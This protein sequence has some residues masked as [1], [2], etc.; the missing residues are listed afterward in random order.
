MNNKKVIFAVIAIFLCIAAAICIPAFA[1]DGYAGLPANIESENIAAYAI[2]EITDISGRK[3]LSKA[4]DLNYKTA[5]KSSSK[6]DGFIIKF[7]DAQTFN[8][9][10]LREKD[11]KVRSFQ[12]SYLAK[13]E[14]GEHWEMFYKQDAI[15]DFRLCAFDEITTSQLKFE[16][17][18]AT[19]IFNI[20]EIEIYN[21]PKKERNKFRVSDYLV[22]PEVASGSSYDPLSENYF[23]PQYCSTINQLHLI[24]VACWNDEGELVINDGY[25]RETIA[26]EV[27]KIREIYGEN[28]VDIFAT[29]F[30]NRCNPT[31][32]LTEHKDEVI[33]NTVDFLVEAGFDGVSYDW[34]YPI[35]EQWSLFNAHLIAL[36]KEL[37]NHGMLLSCAMSG[38]GVK[39]SEEAINAIDQVEIMSYDNFDYRGHNSSFT[40]GAVQPLQYFL[41]LGF[42]KEQI[43]L[44]VPFYGRPIH[45]EGIWVDIDDPAYTP[46]DKFEN[47]SNGMWFSAPQLTR[48]R[49]AYAIAN[50]LGGMM[51]FT[52]A[53]DLPYSH[54]LS[55]IKT[56]HNT[57]QERI[58]FTEKGE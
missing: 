16:V 15:E 39:L 56:I 10:I 34:E 48:D 27:K 36:S 17:T 21:A 26:A 20:R 6:T 4:V 22:L 8:T 40:S 9:I 32:V 12:L 50:D 57:I 1:K 14:N 52:A 3:N 49:V 41:N 28:D 44:G 42:K 33:K 47:F 25:T 11:W 38:F 54:E 5:W 2:E 30:F 51:I 29:V 55:G 45:G 53:E 19:G 18:D 43:N 13:D 58:E 46:A 35:G 24:A 7:K 23:D 31:T 37:H